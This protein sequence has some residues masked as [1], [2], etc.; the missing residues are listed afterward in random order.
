[1]EMTWVKV[2][3]V[4]GVYNGEPF[5]GEAIES[6]LNQTYTDFEFI[7]I[8][9][10]STDSTWDTIQSYA[11]R[12]KRVKAVKNESN[13]GLTRSLNKGIAMAG[14]EYIARQDADDISMPERFARQVEYLDRHP[15]T[16]VV[17]T[18]VEVI[19]GEG[20]HRRKMDLSISAESVRIELKERNPMVHGSVM[21]R[22]FDF[23]NAGGYREFFRYTQDLDLWLRLS[24]KRNIANLPDRLY[25]LRQGGGSISVEKGVH[26]DIFR[27]LALELADRRKKYGKDRLSNMSAFEANS[28]VEHYL[29]MSDLRKKRL[30][31]KKYLLWTQLQLSRGGTSDAMRLLWKAI[32]TDPFHS[33]WM[34]IIMVNFIWVRMRN[35]LSTIKRLTGY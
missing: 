19:D 25:K 15:D 13:I 26:Q 27:D 30:K 32:K 5:V 33:S 11:S 35:F 8:D 1:M 23:E 12:D 17:G 14:G 3:V 18:I 29:E 2:S 24:E 9:D 20:K 10:G 28:F 4:M 31:Q 34:K 16:A 21:M 7:V 6:I 22:K